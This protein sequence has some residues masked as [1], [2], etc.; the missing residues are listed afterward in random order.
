[1][2]SRKLWL[3]VAV[4]GFGIAAFGQTSQLV[5]QSPS[6]STAGTCQSV[7]TSGSGLTLLQF[8]VTVN[9]NITEFHGPAGWEHI[10]AGVPGQE[11]YGVCDND[12]KVRYFDYTSDSGN[13]SNAVIT[14]PGGP[15]TFPLKITRTS[16]DGV[17][18][19]TQ[20]FSRNPSERIAKI[21]MTLKNN[22]G[23]SKTF[24]LVRFANVNANTSSLGTNLNNE[25]DS[26]GDSAWAYNLGLFGV[27]LSTVP[28]ALEHAGF[29]DMTNDGP[30]PCAPGSSSPPTHPFYGDGGVIMAYVLA[31]P[32]GQSKTVG[33]EYKRF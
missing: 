31:L 14:Q 18:T 6:P 25:F 10:A 16:S 21:S 23:S 8:C 33:V 30:D 12:T 4:L 13:W 9:G 29:V 11:G 28:T 26:G 5:S 24:I 17:F 20:A 32:A 27:R 7:F 1:M 2:G 15:N 3:S 19:L 22:A